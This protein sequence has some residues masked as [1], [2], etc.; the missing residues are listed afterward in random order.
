MKIKT[1]VLFK[2]EMDREATIYKKAM[3]DFNV[4]YFYLF[5]F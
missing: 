5:Y 4:L 3:I 2:H 1:V